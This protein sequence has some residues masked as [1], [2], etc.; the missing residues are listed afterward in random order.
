M[1]QIEFYRTLGNRIDVTVEYE[2][3]DGDPVGVIVAD[4]IIIDANLITELRKAADTGYAAM[5]TQAPAQR[6]QTWREIGKNAEKCL[7]AAR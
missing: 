4:G 6:M 7:R 3:E 5:K 2:A 1:Y